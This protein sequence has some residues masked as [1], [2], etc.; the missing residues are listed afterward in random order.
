[1]ANPTMISGTVKCPD[2][3]DPKHANTYPRTHKLLN[4][5]AKALQ[6]LR[7]SVA[8]NSILVDIAVERNLT[9]TPDRR[10]AEAELAK[11]P[12]VSIVKDL[13][14]DGARLWGCIAENDPVYGSEIC[15]NEDLVTALELTQVCPQIPYVIDSLIVSLQDPYLTSAA[16]HRVVFPQ[17]QLEMTPPR[18]GQTGEPN[19]NPGKALEDKLFGGSVE[20]TWLSCDHIGDFTG[21]ERI[22]IRLPRY[23]NALRFLTLDNMNDF[24]HAI[25]AGEIVPLPIRAMKTA[26]EA[27]PPMVSTR[28]LAIVQALSPPIASGITFGPDALSWRAG[29]DRLPYILPIYHDGRPNWTDLE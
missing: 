1:M 18:I 16:I 29:A 10:L 24:L 7:S 3:C 13:K 21:V 26:E 25:Y 17:F 28:G 8:Y 22:T 5:C 12:H 15:M 6:C 14:N 27:M 11:P 4:A 20:V 19:G 2:V 9:D 23:V